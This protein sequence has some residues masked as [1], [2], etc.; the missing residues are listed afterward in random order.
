MKKSKFTEKFKQKHSKPIREKTK[1][2]ALRIPI[3][4]FKD[5]DSLVK[6]T[7]TTITEVIIEA[8]R[9]SFKGE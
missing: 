2:I 6:E 9:D 3:S 7:N 8:L 5:I 4:L 1:L